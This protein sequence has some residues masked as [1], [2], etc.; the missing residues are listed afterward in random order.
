MGQGAE[1]A[2]YM[3]ILLIL[4]ARCN[5]NL[6]VT[7]FLYGLSHLVS[8]SAPVS[9]REPPF[10]FKA[11]SCRTTL[12]TVNAALYPRTEPLSGQRNT[13]P[14][15]RIQPINTA[16]STN[17]CDRCESDL[18]FDIA[19]AYQPIV[20][21]AKRTIFGREALV[22]TAE[23]GPAAEVLGR[24]TDANQYLFDQT[25][26]VQAIRGAAEL[27]MEEMLMINFLPNAVYEPAACIS[28]TLEAAKACGFPSHR[29][30]F[31]VSEGEKVH[32]R[33]HLVNIF[34]EYRRF[35]FRTAIDDF[36]AGY[37][38]LNLLADYQPDMVK[39]DME[40]VRDVDSSVAKQE[41]VKGIVGICKALR[42]DVIAEG[43]ETVE[44]RDFLHRAGINLM[45]GYLFCRPA[46]KGLG[47]IEPAAW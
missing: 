10:H 34:R 13:M 33:K 7:D 11:S 6:N 45:Q 5:Y 24:V 47:T 27:G 29:I 14:L 31:E 40:L 18:P 20:N 28:K 43:V 32:D 23:G 41:I 35:G 12:A 4:L 15:T 9:S 30:V 2:R 39:V 16:G 46:F 22:R 8:L 17:N 38:G 36:G 3:G 37:A 44:E 26:R 25:C 19:F 21:I 1:N 42:V